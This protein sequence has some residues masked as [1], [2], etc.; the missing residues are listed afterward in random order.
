MKTFSAIGRQ[1]V[2][3]AAAFGAAAPVRAQSSG[4]VQITDARGVQ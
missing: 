4:P 3:L 1:A 2:V